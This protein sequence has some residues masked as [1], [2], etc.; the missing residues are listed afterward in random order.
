[1]IQELK[2][3]LTQ[4]MMLEKKLDFKLPAQTLYIDRS[5]V[6]DLKERE[7]NL[8]GF[9]RREKIVAELIVQLASEGFFLVSSSLGNSRFEKFTIA[10]KFQ[11]NLKVEN[12]QIYNNLY[13]TLD[14]PI[15]KFTKNR[16]IVIFS[17]VA[18]LAFNADIA[19]RNF[20]VNFATIGKYIPQ[21]TYILR[22]GD[23]GGII[24][25]FY[26]NTVFSNTIED[27]IQ[28]LLKFILESHN[29]NIDD[30]VLYG[31]SKGGTGALYHGI[32]GGYKSIAVDP[33]VSDEYHEQS[34]GD[35]HFT[36][37]YGEYK[38]YP[39]T[40]QEKF[41]NLMKMNR[42]FNN[43]NIIYSQQ[44]PVYGAINSVIR[45]N[46]KEN[47]INYLNVCH[48]QIKTHPDVAA[49]T[50]N[51]LMLVMN[52]LFYD[53]AEIKSKDI[54]CDESIEKKID[55]KAELKLTKLIVYVY[56]QSMSLRVY[57][58][59]LEKY[60]DIPLKEPI[61]EISLFKLKGKMLSIV[62]TGTSVEYELVVDLKKS[63]VLSKIASYK[64]INKNGKEF[65]FL[66]I[67]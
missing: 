17:S 67:G 38:I 31:G 54:D 26:M 43:I 58:I 36:Q 39:Q 12:L 61:T 9:S 19:K 51:I 57:D 56:N 50:I 27:N 53:L 62:E 25:N 59:S 44:S 55:I 13:Y 7:H 48:P 63:S 18:D 30:V 10:K 60:R 29:I 2:I 37:Q 66:F 23:I 20:F 52:N 49:K 40:K 3:V 16:L 11:S 1:M 35:S 21:N 15:F 42:I 5:K 8:I 32:L 24:G 14:K 45:E 22:I 65:S 4:E 64:N 6:G 28:G 33:I 41:T 34:S 46:D 47:K